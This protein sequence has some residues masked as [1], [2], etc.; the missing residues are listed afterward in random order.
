MP[1]EQQSMGDVLPPEWRESL[2]AIF[3][4]HEVQMVSC[5]LW[6]NRAPWRLDWRTCL[7]SFLLF[8]VTGEVE[9]CL[10]GAKQVVAPGDFLM[11]AEDTWHSLELVRGFRNL[12]QFSL[13]CHIHDRWNRPLL[14]RFPSSSG[15]LPARPSNFRILEEL[16][17]LMA[18]DPES[19][20]QRGEAFVREVLA[21]QL[22]G[23]HLLKA[24]PSSGDER[25]SVVIQKMESGFRDC[26]LSVEN[27]ARE[28]QIT[29]VHLRKIFRRETG[30]SPKQFL[31]A[32][33]LRESTRLLRHSTA[34]IKEVAAAC[35]FASDHYFHLVFREKFGRTPS[36][37]RA[38]WHRQI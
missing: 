23:E 37:Y 11:L 33:R 27:L 18:T 19:G 1:Q 29:P 17:C 5:T 21:A 26:D 3:V 4:D 7:D 20:Q 12:Q 10:R 35:G 8:P 38:D 28:V 16:C 6:K 24:A 22:A 36:G 9:V 25:V 2:R 34:S 14:R 31:Q 15:R 30:D 13:H 32:V